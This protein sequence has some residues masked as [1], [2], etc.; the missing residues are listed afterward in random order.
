MAEFALVIFGIAIILAV[1][2]EVNEYKRK[3]RLKKI[4]DKKY[5]DKVDKYL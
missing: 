4:L 1:G 3:K 5:G 2:H